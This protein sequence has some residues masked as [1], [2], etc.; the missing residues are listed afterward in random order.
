MDDGTGMDGSI[1]EGWHD[2]ST[3]RHFFRRESDAA[4]CSSLEAL[5]PEALEGTGGR[6]Q[7]AGGA[8]N[9]PAGRDHLPLHQR[10]RARG[11]DK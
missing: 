10:R 8:G 3:I 9:T 2:P 5:D 1:D 4:L 11:K 7:W 6:T